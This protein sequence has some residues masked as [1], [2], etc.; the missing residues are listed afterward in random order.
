MLAEAEPDI[1]I[2]DWPADYVSL[3]RLFPVRR[4]G[5]TE[6]YAGCPGRRRRQRGPPIPCVERIDSESDRGRYLGTGTIAPSRSDLHFARVTSGGNDHCALSLVF[7]AARQG[8][9]RSTSRSRAFAERSRPP[10]RLRSRC[11]SPH[12]RKSSSRARGPSTSRLHRT[13]PSWQSGV[14]A[15]RSR[16]SSSRRGRTG[17]GSC[18]MTGRCPDT[19][20]LVYFCSLRS[21]IRRADSC[22]SGGT[23]STSTISP[24]TLPTRTCSPHAARTRPFAFG[25][26]LYPGARTAPSALRTGSSERPLSVRGSRENC[27]PSLR[28]RDTKRQSCPV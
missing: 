2:P 16:S 21:L 10:E 22:D 15:A 25:T 19:E 27:W 18:I 7:E 8:E 24:S 9:S 12:V 3:G 11:C 14:P 23:R 26:L 5:R 17:N 1:L 4:S 13:R 6:P 28:S 20:E